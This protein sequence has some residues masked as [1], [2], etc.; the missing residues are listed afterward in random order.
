MC[1]WMLASRPLERSSTTRIER[2]PCAA[3]R[4][5]RWELMNEAPP[6]TRTRFRFQF[7]PLLLLLLTKLLPHVLQELP[8]AGELVT[9]GFRVAD[10]QRACEAEGQQLDGEAAQDQCADETRVTNFTELPQ[11]APAVLV[12]TQQ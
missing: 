7:I 12:E 3:R 9:Q 8:A 1:A 11:Q 2:A 5:I 10:E 4:S 6:V